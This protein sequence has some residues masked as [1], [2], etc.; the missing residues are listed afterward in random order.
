MNILATEISPER[1]KIYLTN[2]ITLQNKM[3]VFLYVSPIPLI[4]IINK[5]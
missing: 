3:L 2:E 1:K 5:Y 4:I